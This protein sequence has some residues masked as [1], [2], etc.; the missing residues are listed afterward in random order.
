[1]AVDTSERG[2]EG[3]IEHYLMNS[4][5]ESLVFD[6]PSLTSL[7]FSGI[8]KKMLWRFLESTQEKELNHLRR[9]YSV[10][11]AD[12]KIL[13]RILSEIDR[14]G[15]L[16]V[17]RHGVR[18]RGVHLKLIYNKPETELNRTLVENYKKNIFAVSRQV[19]Y[20]HE[21]KNSLDLVLFVNGFPLVVMELKNQLTNQTVYDGMKQFRET[22]SPKE[23]MFQFNKRALVYFA[24]DTD[25]VYMTTELKAEHTNFLP[26][27]LGN[28][29]GKGNPPSEGNYRTYYLWENVL[30][31]DSLLDIIFKFMYIKKDDIRDSNGELLYQRKSLIFPR[32][33]Q[34]DVVRKI[35]DDVRKFSVGQNYLIQHSAGSGKTNSISWLAHRLSKMHDKENKAFFDSVIVIT[36]RRVLDKQLQDAVYQLEHKA[37]TVERID[38]DSNQ[39]AKAIQSGT[40]IVITTLQKFPYVLDKIAKLSSKNYAVVIDEAHSSQGGKSAKAMSQVLS[41]MTLEE[42]YEQDRLIED[43]LT[44]V[45][46]MIVEDIVKSG[47]QTNVSYF[48][49]TATP[50]PKTLERFGRKNSEGKFI[51]FHLY[52]MRQAIEEGFILDVLQNYTTYKTYYNIISASDEKVLKSEATKKI[53]RFVSLHPHSIAQKVEVIVEHFRERTQ[54]KL[55]G[56]AKAMLVT[57][58]RLHAVRYKLAMDDY[59]KRR[60]YKDM[61]TLVAFSGKVE[62]GNDTPYTESN[63]N[64]FSENELPDKFHTDDF[65]VLIVAEKY[66]TG[67]DEPLLQTMYVDKPLSGV[68]AVQTLSRLNRTCP[69][70]SDTFILDFVNETEEI[71]KAFQP[72]YETTALES[73]TDPNL[74]YELKDTIDQ[75]EIVTLEELDTVASLVMSG[76]LESSA[77]VQGKLNSIIDKGVE[78]YIGLD[79]EDQEIFRDASVKYLRTYGFLLQIIDFA[80]VELHKMYLYVNYLI[81]KL[82]KKK[83]DTFNLPDDVALKYYKIKQTS[84]GTIVLEKTG[85]EY[86]EGVGH[87]VSP[88]IEEEEVSFSDIINKI[89]ERFGTNFEP[90]DKLFMDQVTRKMHSDES[91]VMKAK[92]NSFDNFVLGVEKQSQDIL[93]DKYET[94]SK[95]VDKY[96]TDDE[97]KSFV[98]TY[99]LKDVY[100]KVH[101]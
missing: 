3:N 88:I 40:R 44:D 35:E 21:S 95:F 97:F 8:D 63:M 70:K 60:H 42:A 93:I 16:D 28:Q 9:K 77:T 99:M 5:Y 96:L 72:Y 59:I 34:L 29:G 81:R 7:R 43:N 39:L 62:D 37:G 4:S 48:A 61:E 53:G 45:E 25:E 1:M 55:D 84:V 76:K 15:L 85:I 22:R 71:K 79:T 98:L 91:F 27:N 80:D 13:E 86:I 94:N 54:H 67:F 18:D 10:G 23:L 38:K 41:N 14:K 74:L 73:E 92:N 46:E 11:N 51:P 66:Q 24:V 47:K 50:K 83:R 30:Q 2:F 32:Y 49:F 100:E 17:L 33:H 69:G 65:Q 68:K 101:N 36:D 26:F 12:D 19:Y 56:R 57:S 64:G 31:K 20:T 58:S 52:S 82:P 75:Y 6:K 89:N 90:E 87:G 78:R